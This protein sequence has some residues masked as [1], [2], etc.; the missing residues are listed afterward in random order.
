MNGLFDF[1]KTPQ[2]Q[3]LLAAG[4]GMAAN[5]GRGGTLNTIGR[6]GLL[7][8]AGYANA[9]NQ[10]AERGERAKMAELRDMQIA[11]YRAEVEAKNRA[12][13][14]EQAKLAAVPTLFRAG[15]MTGGEA[16]PQQMG[17]V[18]MFSKPAG[19]TPMQSTPGGFDVMGAIQAGFSPDEI[20][21][22]VGLQD[23]G[24]PKA[25]RQMEVDDGRGGKKIVLADDFGR[26][27]AGFAGY[28]AP[29]QVNQGDRVSFVKPAP[30]VSLGVNMSPAERDA[31]ARGW[32]GNR[33]TAERL[34]FDKA[35]GADANR[36]PAG[37][38]WNA[39]RTAQEIIP[40]GPADLKASAEGQKK[41]SEARDVLGLL[42]EVDKLLPKATGSYAGVGADEA[43]RFFGFSTPGAE[44]TAQLKTIQGALISKMP[45]MS[46]PQSD[47]DVQ[48]YREM[49]GQVADATLPVASRQKAAD[50]IRR[51]NE[52]YAGLPEGSSKAAVAVVKTGIYG[53]R[54]VEQLS[55]GTVRY[56]D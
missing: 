33:L 1:L 24:R 43:A 27:V 6:G 9:E 32:A 5:A 28:T 47:K 54:K 56:A 3:G 19:V 7:G 13:A 22:Y 4:L 53:G 25:T 10:Q 2:G 50:T 23:A 38:R 36:A 17:G 42:D 34:A 49:A 48:L 29:V 52:K 46:G 20:Q 39:D 16:A 8:L 21:K 44:T 51:L 55:D 41:V 26:E 11:N 45:K 12:N 14:R 37:Y 30:G 18:E 35:G 40:G 15:G 31:S